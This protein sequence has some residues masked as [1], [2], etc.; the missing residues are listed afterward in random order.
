MKRDCAVCGRE[1]VDGWYW[2]WHETICTQCHWW[3]LDLD[4]VNRWVRRKKDG[5]TFV[6]DV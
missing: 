5:D 2:I 6:V 1:M 3:V 4:L